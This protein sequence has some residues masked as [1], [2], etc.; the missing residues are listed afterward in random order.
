MR[1][2]HMEKESQKLMIPTCG[3]SRNSRRLDVMTNGGRK[4]KRHGRVEMESRKRARMEAGDSRSPQI[5]QHP[6]L[7]H[8]YRQ[9]S[10]LRSYLISRLPLSARSRRRNIAS[11][12]RSQPEPCENG[13]T[14]HGQGDGTAAGPSGRSDE[15][16]R[17]SDHSQTR[18]AALLDNTVVCT[19][20]GS[21]SEFKDSREKDYA[22]FSQ[23]ADVTLGSTLDEGTTSISD[24]SSLR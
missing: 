1:S 17:R 14:V 18:L 19:S 10:S 24:V 4:R 11:A 3:L 23:K 5:L 22:A 16:D 6:T 7:R 21:L 8:Y 15:S 20:D 13:T 9:R 2:R 12:G